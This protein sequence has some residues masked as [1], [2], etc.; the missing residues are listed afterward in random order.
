MNMFRTSIQV[1]YEE[2]QI[3]SILFYYE[4]YLSGLFYFDPLVLLLFVHKNDV[5]ISLKERK[6]MNQE[7]HVI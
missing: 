6:G 5:E 3:W 1:K 4:V 2:K 7:V